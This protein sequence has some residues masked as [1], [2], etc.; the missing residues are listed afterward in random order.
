MS[1]GLGASLTPLGDTT[2]SGGGAS[3]LTL[4]GNTK[5]VDTLLATKRYAEVDAFGIGT[6][7]TLTPQWYIG[8]S[9]AELI[10]FQHSLVPNV[11]YSWTVN[12]QIYLRQALNTA[13]AAGLS[14]VIH[15]QPVLT[16]VQ[17]VLV[18]QGLGIA[19]SPLPSLKYTQSLIQTLTL[20]DSLRNFF[21]AGM[22]DGIGLHPALTQQL[23]VNPSI[24]DAINIAPALSNHFILSVT[25]SDAINLGDADVLKMIYSGEGLSD[26]IEIVA[27]YVSPDGNFTTWAINTRTAAVSEYS[28]YQF[29]SFCRMGNIYY[30]ANS[31]GLYQLLGDDDDGADI[32]AT[33]RSGF[34]QWAGSRFTMFKGIY[35]GVRGEGDWVLKLITGDDNTYIYSVST[36]NQRTTKVHLGK[37]LR[38]RYWQFELTSTGQDFDIDTIEFVP[39]VADRRV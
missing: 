20:H 21:G 2:G 12:E 27:G 18:M 22:A 14:D 17:A 35:L 29:N 28:N 11:K 37:G 1:G 4:S 38:A 32:I 8:R 39:L 34:A 26:G 16:T 9:I 15:V 6:H 19:A 23:R 7:P 5:V 31:S 36:R 13:F 30:G 24:G 3:Q 10:H 25:A 33:L